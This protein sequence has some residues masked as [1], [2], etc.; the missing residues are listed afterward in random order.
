MIIEKYTQGLNIKHPNTK[1]IQKLKIIWI[2]LKLRILK[3]KRFMEK[4][5]RQSFNLQILEAFYLHKKEHKLKK[6]PPKKIQNLLIL[7]IKS[8]KN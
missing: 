3:T 5:I 6:I 4:E 7:T 2:K 1:Q 8:Y